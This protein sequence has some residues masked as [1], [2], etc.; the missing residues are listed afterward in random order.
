[1]QQQMKVV[2]S[3]TPNVKIAAN[4]IRFS[5]DPRDV[6]AEKAARRL[7]LTLARF[8][9]VEG[10]LY[11]RGFP[12]PDKTTG[13]FDLLA[14]DRWMDARWGAKSEAEGSTA[15]VAMDARDVFAERARRLSER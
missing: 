10:E 5:V 12:R 13:N 14:I 9:V 6:P 3:L 8:L 4:S 15:P 7:G 11:E 2:G 1:M